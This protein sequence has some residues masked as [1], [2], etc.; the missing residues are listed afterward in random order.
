[1]QP[2]GGELRTLKLR[3]SRVRGEWCANLPYSVDP[4]AEYVM[5]GQ[6]AKRK[7]RGD[8]RDVVFITSGDSKA[9]ESINY[10]AELA[11]QE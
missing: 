6:G 11:A 9:R 3:W 7:T 2:T 10:K 8:S 1:M 5:T 4:D